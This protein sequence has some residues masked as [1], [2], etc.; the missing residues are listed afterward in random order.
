MV[1]K[2]CNGGI[3]TPTCLAQLSRDKRVDRPLPPMSI[4]APSASVDI[5][6]FPV[7]E[8]FDIIETQDNSDQ[9]VL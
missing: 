8:S 9:S 7:V 6:I 5:H 1:L 2:V 4:L 3:W